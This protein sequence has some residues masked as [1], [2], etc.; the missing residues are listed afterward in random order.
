M[1]L[2]EIEGFLAVADHLHF[3][4][5]A[6][7]LGVSSSRVSQTIQRLERRIGAQLFDRTTRSVALTG[8]GRQLLADLRPG[9]ERIQQAIA[10]AIEAGRGFDGVLTVGFIGAAAGQL[11]HAAGA[12]FQIEHPQTELRIR[13]VRLADGLQHWLCEVCDMVLISRPIDD[14]ALTVGPTL[15]AERRVLAV[16]A[17]HPLAERDTVELEDLAE[18]TLLRVPDSWPASLLEDRIPHHTPSGRAIAHGTVAYTFQELLALIGAGAGAFIVGDQVTRFYQRPDVTFVPIRDA[19]PL[20]WG[21]AWRAA[22]ETAKIR[23]FAEVAQ[24]IGR[25]G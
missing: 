8:I 13:D 12:R 1:E 6:T 22:D 25:P 7:Q 4:R 17:R 5:A 16:S 14:P 9:H 10:R 15:I 18:V 3:G 23:A 20:E 2:Y 24:S 19:P 21:F 11:T